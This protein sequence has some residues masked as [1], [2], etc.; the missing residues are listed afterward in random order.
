MPFSPSPFFKHLQMNLIVEG[1]KKMIMTGASGPSD[2]WGGYSNFRNKI[3]QVQ[4][5]F[6][7][8]KFL[9]GNSKEIPTLPFW[10]ELNLP[11]LANITALCFCLIFSR[12]L[13]LLPIC[14]PCLTSLFFSTIP[15][16]F[17]LVSQPFYPFGIQVWACGNFGWGNALMW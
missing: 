7:W 10:P 2:F 11:F 15:C 13:E 12:F 17:S 14:C 9:Q 3:Y 8:R 6:K 5:G 16:H 1:Y 4:T